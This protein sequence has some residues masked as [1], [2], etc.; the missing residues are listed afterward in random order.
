MAADALT[1]K[2][3]GGERVINT[4]VLLGTG[5]NGNG[6]REVLGTRVAT[7]QTGTVRNSFFADLLA[8]GLSGVRLITSDAH[9]GLVEAITRLVGAAL[10]EQ[11]YESTEARRYLGPDVLPHRH[12]N[13]SPQTSTKET[14][15]T[16]L[17][18]LTT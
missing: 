15:T 9:T 16:P 18:T 14:T 4:V 8:R 3:R 5:L 17:P 6:H 1:M 10:D 12:L 2:V 7:G 11:T 13:T